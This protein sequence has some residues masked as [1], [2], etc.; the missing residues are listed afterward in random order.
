[1][2]AGLWIPVSGILLEFLWVTP[3]IGALLGVALAKIEGTENLEHFAAIVFACCAGV[4][5][6]ER[7][8]LPPPDLENPVVTEMMD[9]PLR[10]LSEPN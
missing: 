6:Y 7:E 5:I 1:M 8:N 9:K 2:M 4:L 10:G 3:V